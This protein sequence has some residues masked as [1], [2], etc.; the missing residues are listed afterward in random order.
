MC[1]YPSCLESRKLLHR[2]LGY[3]LPYWPLAVASLLILFTGT[4]I[5]LMPPLLL[6]TLIDD[7]LTPVTKN[8]LAAISLP[9]L[10]PTTPT[11]AASLANLR[12]DPDQ[13][14]AQ[15]SQRYTLLSST[16]SR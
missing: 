1:V 8:A 3:S 7:V 12:L 14:P 9:F 6:R 2:F 5:G 11:G 15:R 4:F 13:R 16:P 10:G